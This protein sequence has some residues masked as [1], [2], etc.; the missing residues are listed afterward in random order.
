MNSENCRCIIPSVFWWFSGSRGVRCGTDC[1]NCEEDVFVSTN[2]RNH[3]LEED[4]SKRMTLSSFPVKCDGRNPRVSF[5]RAIHAVEEFIALANYPGASKFVIWKDSGHAQN[6]W[7]LNFGS[8]RKKH[9]LHRMESGVRWIDKVK[10]MHIYL[11]INSL[12]PNKRNSVQLI[13]IIFCSNQLLHSKV[14]CLGD[15]TLSINLLRISTSTQ[16]RCMLLN[17]LITA[18]A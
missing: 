17:R 18:N 6:L 12:H 3:I 10:Y 14:F 2:R 4:P 8:L 7:N 1:R 9:K 16:C 11:V 15:S 5:L 13:Q